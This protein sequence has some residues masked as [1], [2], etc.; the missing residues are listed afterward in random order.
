MKKYCYSS[1]LFT[2][3]DAKKY[4]HPEDL[5]QVEHTFPLGWQLQC[6]EHL[7]VES[8]F[9]ILATYEI[10]FRVKNA[11]VTEIDHPKYFYGDEVF[12]IR[13]NMKGKVLM[14]YWHYKRNEP[15]YV[16]ECAGVE[17]GYRYFNKDL[18]DANAGH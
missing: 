9:D 17:S 8:G 4:I 2:H 5:R 16:I 18:E 14:V 3:R 10:R 11:V 6:F 15:Y 7:G 1:L 12:V 13:K